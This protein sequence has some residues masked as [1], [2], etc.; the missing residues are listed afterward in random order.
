MSF[1][2]DVVGKA[3]DLLATGANNLS[4]R[5]TKVYDASKNKVYIGGLELDGVVNCTVSQRIYTRQ[6]QGVHSSYYT[7]FD[8][9]EPMTLTISVLP[10]AKCNDLMQ[11]L[12]RKQR[13]FKGY[14]N[15]YIQE[16]GELRDIFRGHFLTLPEINMSA[17]APDVVYTC[18]I[19]ST[20]HTNVFSSREQVDTTPELTRQI[21]EEILNE[22]L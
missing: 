14:F 21:N 20:M 7:Y 15:I 16:N 5:R 6:Q 8:V 18:G 13:E 10:T 19:K 9:E 17:D 3:K 12:A 2:N 4:N 11:M 22:G 1:V